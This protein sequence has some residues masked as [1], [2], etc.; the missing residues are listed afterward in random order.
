MACAI[1]DAMKLHAI[2]SDYIANILESRA[3]KLPEPGALHLTRRTD[4]LDIAVEAPDLSIYDQSNHTGGNTM[5]D[6]KT[7]NQLEA[8]LRM[9]GLTFMAEHYNQ[10]C[11]KRRP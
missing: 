4:L 9:L 7:T 5:N 11:R 6:D 8:D 10:S 3:R 1:D 2:G